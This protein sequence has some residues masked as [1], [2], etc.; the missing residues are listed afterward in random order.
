MGNEVTKYYDSS[1]NIAR[2]QNQGNLLH[3]EVYEMK[4]HDREAYV[5]YHSVLF[6]V[7]VVFVVFS[8][9]KSEKHSRIARVC[10]FLCPKFFTSAGE[11]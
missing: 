7:I 2:N 8:E 9:L 5:L 11:T 4:Y 3:D 1:V 6:V 10:T